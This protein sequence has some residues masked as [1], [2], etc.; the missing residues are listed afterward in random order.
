MRCSPGLVG[1]YTADEEMRAKAS[2]P[3]TQIPKHVH[4]E[5]RPMTFETKRSGD[6]GS[7]HSAFDFAFCSIF[8]LHV[9]ANIVI[10]KKSVL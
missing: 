4:V 3:A 7:C 9:C 1:S 6:F 10:P 8:S 2:V 5:T